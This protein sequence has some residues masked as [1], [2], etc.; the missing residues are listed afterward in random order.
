LGIT[1][2]FDRRFKVSNKVNFRGKMK[3]LPRL[4]YIVKK[5]LD[6]FFKMV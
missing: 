1:S 2:R 3:I 4:L 6:R 5:G